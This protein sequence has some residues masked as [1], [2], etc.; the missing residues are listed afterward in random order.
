MSSF[1]SSS[2]ITAFMR[3]SNWPRYFVPATKLARSKVTTRLSK[4]IL[5]TFR[6][7][8][9]SASPS[10]IA[11]LPTPGSPIN[12]GLFFFLLLKICETLSISFSLPTTGSSL[13]FSAMAVKSLPKLS[14]TGVFD[15]LEVFPGPLPP[16]LNG[17]SF[18][19]SPVLLSSSEKD[20]AVGLS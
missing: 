9:L 13:S 1:F 6:C 11:D 17:L 2:F 15:F 14:K 12:N 18:V 3:S 19:A 8:I 5:E 16:P 10:A 20:S 4:S 7:T